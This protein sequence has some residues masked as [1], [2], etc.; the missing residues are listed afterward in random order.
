MYLQAKGN[1][2][3]AKRAGKR[4]HRRGVSQLPFF[5]PF[6]DLYLSCIWGKKPGGKQKKWEKGRKKE[7]K[8]GG[9]RATVNDPNGADYDEAVDAVRTVDASSLGPIEKVAALRTGFSVPSEIIRIKLFAC[10]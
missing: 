3:G 4:E 6:L 9:K 8:K 7:V 5:W 2:K 10:A 1:K